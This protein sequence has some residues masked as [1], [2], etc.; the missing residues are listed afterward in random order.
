LERRI[1]TSILR[2]DIGTRREEELDGRATSRGRGYQ[3][4]SLT[5][6]APLH[7]DLPTLCQQP[8]E[9][10]RVSVHRGGQHRSEPHVGWLRDFHDGVGIGTLLQQARDK[11]GVARPG[12][13]RVQGGI[14]APRAAPDIGTVIKQ[15]TN[16]PQVSALTCRHQGG[17]AP[18]AGIGVG[19]MLGQEFQERSG[20]G[21]AGG[22]QK[23]R[24]QVAGAVFQKQLDF[25]HIVERPE[26]S[27]CPAF[28]ACGTNV[29]TLLQQEFHDGEIRIGS[30]MH[31]RGRA[32][33][34][35]RVHV[36]PTTEKNLD[37]SRVSVTDGREEVNVC[38]GCK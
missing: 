17:K 16:G 6:I 10:I 3:E 5:K 38:I 14:T 25:F 27:R 19:P 4:G 21:D 33:L 26:Q 34:V 22:A 7:V 12:S 1:A 28:F 37:G 20:T 31:E 13:R 8:L 2:L 32:I 9:A 24:V 36:R 18:L 11:V 15:I 35:A 23:R 29:G 30:C